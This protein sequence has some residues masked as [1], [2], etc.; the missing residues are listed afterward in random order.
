MKEVQYWFTQTE[1]A[2]APA[3]RKVGHRESFQ[4]TRARRAQV[5]DETERRIEMRRNVIKRWIRH[6]LHV[7]WNLFLQCIRAQ[8]RAR[9]ILQRIRSRILLRQM[10]HAFHRYV[11]AVNTAIEQKRK[12]ATIFGRHLADAFHR[13]AAVVAVI[14]EQKQKFAKMISAGHFLLIVGV[15]FK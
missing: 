11:A 5:A 2:T 8:G 1:D 9:Q 7:A 3:L 6:H 10:D 14:V 4:K 13:Y 15:M 12:L